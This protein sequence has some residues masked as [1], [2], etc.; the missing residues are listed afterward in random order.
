MTDKAQAE[1]RYREVTAMLDRPASKNTISK[2]KAANL[3]SK[4][5]KHIAKLAAR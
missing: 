3:K 5:A 4:L 1:A 2:N